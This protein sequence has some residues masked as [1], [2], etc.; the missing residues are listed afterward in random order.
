MKNLRSFLI[1]LGLWIL[2]GSV[3]SQNSE[4]PLFTF[5][6]VADVQ[7][8]DIPDSGTR[9]YL[10]SPEK[11]A[12]AVQ[13]F[14]R[15]EVA[16]VMSLGDFIND[17]MSGFDTLNAITSKLT[18]PIYHVAGNHD[19]DPENPD[20][21]LT[22]SSM[23]LKNLHYYFLKQGMRFIV[24]NGNDISIYTNCPGTKGY[25]K[26]SALLEE[27]RLKGLPQAQPW[28][29]A[30]GKKQLKWLK[31]ELEKSNSQNE[32]VIIACHFPIH[33]EKTEG[34][35]WNS[36]AVNELISKYPNVYAYLSGH[37]HISQHILSEGIHHLMFRGMVEGNDNSFAIV[38]VYPDRIAIEGFGKE[39]SRI[40]KIK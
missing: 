10:K 34:R 36:L 13:L 39:V 22:M 14:N 17:K 29:G 5:G 4:K 15:S 11:L 31:K 27:M 20:P 23:N 40:L 1:L 26:A 35:L 28:N 19:F 7:Y 38:S 37:G 32:R 21:K 25:L 12:E 18:M 24:L 33:S 2:C 9:H 6:I 30:I 16:F 8:A 3:F